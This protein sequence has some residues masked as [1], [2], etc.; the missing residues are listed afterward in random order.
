MNIC[1]HGKYKVK[2]RNMFDVRTYWEG[3]AKF[4]TYRERST[5]MLDGYDLISRIRSLLQ[6]RDLIEYAV[7]DN[8]I[9]IDYF[10]PDDGTGQT[11]TY[12][13]T[14]IKENENGDNRTRKKSSRKSNKNNP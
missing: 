7:Y 6:H 9:R 8:I 5:I 2:I 3:E 12:I 4:E 13:I 10:N 1:V 11:I 14:E